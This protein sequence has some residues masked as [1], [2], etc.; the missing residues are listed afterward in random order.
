MDGPET[1]GLTMSKQMC[2]KPIAPVLWPF[3][4]VEG[5]WDKLMLWAHIYDADR[6][7]I[8]YQEGSVGD[9][10]APGELRAKW[11]HPPARDGI[12]PSRR[13]EY[14]LEDPVL[15]RRIVHGYDVDELPVRV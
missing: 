1:Y 6:T 11:G 9:M 12:R 3:A 14:E 15:G 10:R 7:R 8:P 5:H 2:D 4:S 13:F